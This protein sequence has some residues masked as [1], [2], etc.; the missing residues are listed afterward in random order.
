MNAN[1]IQALKLIA[2]TRGMS[3][4]HR[5][6]V[7]V[8]RQAKALLAD[9]LISY[10]SGSIAYI[11]TPAGQRALDTH[12]KTPGCFSAVGSCEH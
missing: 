10:G 12:C 3:L 2:S 11:V 5:G 8:S 7:I 6:N 1:Q 9:G 4:T